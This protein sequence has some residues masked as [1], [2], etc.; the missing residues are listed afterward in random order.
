[1]TAA[2]APRGDGTGLLV[3]TSH[4]YAGASATRERRDRDDP[5]DA[6]A[7]FGR[8]DDDDPRD[9][10]DRDA[11]DRPPPKD[12]VATLMS[13]RRFRSPPAPFSDGTEI[14]E[15]RV[16]VEP[17]DALPENRAFETRP[18]CIFV[19]PPGPKLVTFAFFFGA[20]FSSFSTFLAFF[21]AAV[22][23]SFPRSKKVPISTFGRSACRASG[24]SGRFMD[25]AQSA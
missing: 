2:T 22:A 13:Q 23:F 8:R 3:T 21:A 7:D 10:W 16:W 19:P 1:M 11:T 25:G 9:V 4:H 6:L 14:L 17:T 5:S 20:F 18:F 24:A 12:P 15:A